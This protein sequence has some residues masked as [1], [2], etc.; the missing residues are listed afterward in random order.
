M[1]SQFSQKISRFFWQDRIFHLPGLLTR[2]AQILGL[3]CVLFSITQSWFAVPISPEALN[4]AFNPLGYS[5]LG[6]GSVIAIFHFTGRLP[7]TR[8]VQWS[9][10]LLALSLLWPPYVMH[11]SVEESG[12][13]A[14]LSIEMDTMNWLGGDVFTSQEKAQSLFME[15]VLLTDTPRNTG[16]VPI[17]KSLPNLM[18]FGN[19]QLLF[20]YL[21]YHEAFA[22]FANRGWFLFVFG[23]VLLSVS[24]IRPQGASDPAQLYLWLSGFFFT[25]AILIPLVLSPVFFAARHIGQ[26]HFRMLQSEYDQSLHH[27]VLAVEHLPL[28]NENSTFILQKGL[29]ERRL[30]MDTAEATLYR[31][32]QLEIHHHLLQSRVMLLELAENSSLPT[33]IRREIHRCLL[34]HAIYL[35]NTRKLE[36]AD[37]LLKLLL[38]M[39]PTSIKAL[40]CK[41]HLAFLLNDYKTVFD[42]ASSVQSILS[43]VH[44]PRKK[45][46]LGIVYRLAARAAFLSQDLEQFQYWSSKR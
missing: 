30:G 4:H 41:Q 29:I 38:G 5:I 24:L 19:F 8:T 40:Y 31:C 34:R 39:T 42:C 9:G 28:L 2:C 16:V 13:A 6:L 18:Q 15:D 32:Y 44:S 20:A 10:C 25:L 3:L 17:P 45:P 35:I 36:Q 21:G 43:Q 12:A 14:A 26:A 27:L 22:R 7:R 11:F 37:K 46:L 23:V 1:P 33:Y